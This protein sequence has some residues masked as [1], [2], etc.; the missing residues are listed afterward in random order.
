MQPQVLPLCSH[1]SSSFAS[2]LVMM[3]KQSTAGRRLTPSR[4]VLLS[5]PGA[6][7]LLLQR[8]APGS[9]ERHCTKTSCL[10]EKTKRKGRGF[11]H[12]TSGGFVTNSTECAV[13]AIVLSRGAVDRCWRRNASYTRR[14]LAYSICMTCR[15]KPCRRPSSPPSHPASARAR[16]VTIARRRLLARVF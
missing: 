4:A 12:E 9:L 11:C 7:Q 2:G 16:D 6:C 14:P 10:R 5:R 3:R 13:L 1:G 15:R 8:H